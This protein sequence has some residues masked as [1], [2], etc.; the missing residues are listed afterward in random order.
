V[1]SWPGFLWSAKPGYG[2]RQQ[3]RGMSSDL[4]KGFML[5]EAESITTAR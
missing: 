4:D 5:T 1:K 3:R 2:S